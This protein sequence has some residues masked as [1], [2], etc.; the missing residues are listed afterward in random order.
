MSKFFITL[1]LFAV[2]FFGTPLAFAEETVTLDLAE[3][4]ANLYSWSLGIGVMLALGV[5]AFAGFLYV[6]SSGNP[7]RMGE[8]KKWITAA[9]AGLIVLFSSYL[10]LSTI[11][12]GLTNLESIFLSLNQEQEFVAPELTLP[13]LSGYGPMQI[14]PAYPG[15]FGCRFSASGCEVDPG[16]TMC[17]GAYSPN[18][19]V[20][21]DIPRS[22]YEEC[23]NTV[24]QFCRPGV[25][26]LLTPPNLAN[27]VFVDNYYQLP[28]ST[29]GSYYRGSQG[30]ADA[31]CGKIELIQVIYTVAQNFNGRLIVRDL[32]GGLL[33]SGI[34]HETHDMGVDV[35]IDVGDLS[36]SKRIELA[37]LFINTGIVT[38]MLHDGST[39]MLN[40]VNNYFR[41][42]QPRLIPW[43]GTQFMRSIGNH[44]SHF[45][46]RIGDGDGAMG[47]GLPPGPYN[48]SC[49]WDTTGNPNTQRL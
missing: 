36:E 11:N 9:I 8:A 3:R 5:L 6:T 49:Q 19:D 45:H 39:G 18:S 20:C 41:T 31:S 26:G 25:L 10:I 1:F 35:D 2:V 7:S 4:T 32:N 24:D 16:Q 22:Q 27:V 37:K 21:T 28:E 48:T 15:T 47:T 17:A 46:V 40:T 42:T 43:K 34:N 12:P 38:G 44:P 23:V 13:A 29:D 30:G 14:F 33:N